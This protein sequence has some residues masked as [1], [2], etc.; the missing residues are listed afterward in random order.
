MSAFLDQLAGG[1]RRS[2]STSGIVVQQVPADPSK[3]VE[4][5][6]GLSTADPLVRMRC[7]DVAETHPE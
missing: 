3:L 7:A 4:I 5:I 1:D 2:I 6:A